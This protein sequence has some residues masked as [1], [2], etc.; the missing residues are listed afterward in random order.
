MISSSPLE[1]N[2]KKLQQYVN[3]SIDAKYRDYSFSYSVKYSYLT[4]QQKNSVTEFEIEEFS[5][6]LMLFVRKNR[7]LK[8]I[9]HDIEKPDF[10]WEGSFVE[11]LS[12]EEKKTYV[13]YDF[14]SFNILEFIKTPSLYDETLPHL[15]HIIDYVVCI[16]YLKYLKSLIKPEKPQKPTNYQFVEP[17][18]EKEHKVKVREESTEQDFGAKFEEWEIDLLTKCINDSRIFSKTITS[19][20]MN[21]IFFCRLKF[22]LIIA[23]GKNKLLAYFFTSLDDRS[24]IIRN[25]QSLCER[26]T[27]FQSFSG[28]ILKQNDYSSNVYSNKIKEPK[29]CHIIDKYI[30]QLTKD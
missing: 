27:L 23:N 6:K 7:V 2:I 1:K 12:G 25:W 15:S 5:N 8:Q 22:P 14:S 21:E 19:E 4:E 24:L 28:H 17:Q 29:D 26:K 10:L 13:E 11:C 9:I 3:D 18:K 30:K 20:T 16:R